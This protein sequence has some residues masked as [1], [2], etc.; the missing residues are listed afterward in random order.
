MFSNIKYLCIDATI[1]EAAISELK[2]RAYAYRHSIRRMVLSF[3]RKS[4]CIYIDKEY[5]LANIEANGCLYP[6]EFGFI[7][8]MHC[9]DNIKEYPFTCIAKVTNDRV[10]ELLSVRSSWFGEFYT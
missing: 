2:Y 7:H 4:L 6:Y 10:K 3:K 1:N 5:I 9:I 8:T